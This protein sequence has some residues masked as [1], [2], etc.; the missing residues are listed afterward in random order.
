MEIDK[1]K[2]EVSDIITSN[3]INKSIWKKFLNLFFTSSLKEKEEIIREVKHVWNNE[4]KLQKK[5][6]GAINRTLKD[7]KIIKGY[8]IYDALPDYSN[9]ITELQLLEVQG[10]YDPKII[11]NLR[12][13]LIN[14]EQ[15]DKSINEEYF[16][17]IQIA[18]RLL[19]EYIRINTLFPDIL[20]YSPDSKDKPE[21]NLGDT[22]IEQAEYN[23]NLLTGI[24]VL[25]GIDSLDGEIDSFKA[26]TKLL[27]VGKVTSPYLNIFEGLFITGSAAIAIIKHLN[28][29]DIDKNEISKQLTSQ[30]GEK[31][32]EEMENIFDQ[33]MEDFIKLLKI[34]LED[35]YKIGVELAKHENL[36]KAH[37]DLKYSLDGIQES[38]VDS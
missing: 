31:Y 16:K 3:I 35:R 27:E 10:A 38:L 7:D 14:K 25:F 4:K 12:T 20:Q 30:I 22:L 36:L 21:K 1:H 17:S 19:L 15:T 9:G 23:K 8:K 24:A 2:S 34:K 5:I 37:R 6:T 13:I 33:S 18:P 32:F 28:K 11:D 29:H 26:F